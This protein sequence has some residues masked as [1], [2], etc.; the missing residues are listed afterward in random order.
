L[1]GTALP[2]P[3]LLMAKLVAVVLLATNHV[4]LMP[5]PFLPF[6]DALDAFAFSKAFQWGLKAVFVAAALAIVFNRAVRLSCL[7]LGGAI[8]VAVV[9]S[10][11]YYG[12]NKTMCGILLVLAGLWEPKLGTLFLRLQLALVYFGAGLNKLLDADWQTGQF[13]HHWA[14]ARLQQ[15]V[16]LAL[17]PMFPDLVV[18]KLFCWATFVAELCLS[19]MLLVPRAWPWAIWLNLLFQAALLEFTGTTFTMFFYAMTAASLAF[20]VWPRAVLVIYDGDCG[21]CN[22]IRR[23]WSRLDWD[24]ALEWRTLQSGIG[25]AHGIERRALEESMHVVVDD[26]VYRGFGASKMILLHN[27]AMYLALAVLIALPP[28]SWRTWRRLVVA[29]ALAF[30]FPAFSFVGEAVYRWVARNRHR[31]SSSGACSVDVR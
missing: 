19:A 15:P 29:V 24:R 28:E 2:V 6:V 25:A 5:D 1:S 3:I 8:L 4:R 9:S 13:F 14:G 22:D 20:A 16:Y 12:N 31:F 7:A 11:A 17:A 30:F 18:A 23:W 21:I 27:P 10:K 26:R